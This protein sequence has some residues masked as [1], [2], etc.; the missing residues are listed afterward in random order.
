MTE[1]LESNQ[2]TAD[3]PRPIFI[4]G[5]PRSGTSIMNWAIGQHPNIQVMPETAWIASYALGALMSYRKGSERGKF[6]HLSNVEYPQSLFTEHVARSIHL[7]VCDVYEQRCQR[8]YGD[9]AVKGINITAANPNQYFQVRRHAD[10]PKQRWIDG[11]P[12]NSSHTLALSQVFPGARFIHNLRNPADV[13]LSLENFDKVGASPQ[14]LDE[15]LKTWMRHTESALLAERALGPE[16][17][18]R[19]DFERI[20]NDAEPM[21]RELLAFLGEAYSPCCLEPLLQRTNSSEVDSKRPALEKRLKRRRQYKK[22]RHLFED[23][24]DLTLTADKQSK[25]KEILA[26]RLEALIAGKMLV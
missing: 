5:S 17:V 14:K 4:I 16:K 23:A 11:T 2:T 20:E 10:E 15:G 9:Y 24:Q 13:A 7:I 3:T 25:A 12:L 18:F 8:L 26:D 21:I 19:L 6:S 22:A 1:A